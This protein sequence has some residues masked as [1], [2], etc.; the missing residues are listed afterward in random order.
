VTVPDWDTALKE[1]EAARSAFVDAY[2]GIP[3]E[4]LAF[5]KP[6]EDYALGGLVTHVVAV[7]EHYQLVLSAVVDA[8]FGEVRPEDPPGFWEQQRLR[9]H[10]G[11]Q[12]DERE[13]A[14]AELERRHGGF[15]A[16]MASLPPEDWNRK[17]PV[18]FGSAAEVL[19]TSPGDICE[20]LNGHYLEHVPQVQDLHKEWVAGR[21]G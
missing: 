3:D 5:L 15:I 17:A 18:W 19:P 12:P 11:L 10:A 2:A 21:T 6:G 14:F 13:A 9:A 4:A 1:F 20:W 8:E 16:I 7:L